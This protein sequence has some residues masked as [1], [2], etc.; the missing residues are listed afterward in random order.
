MKICK[1]CNTEKSLDQYQKHGEYYPLTCKSC[2][3][4]ARRLKYDPLNQ[5]VLTAKRK[6]K[7]M[8][9]K[10]NDPEAYRVY[11]DN[12]NEIS[13]TSN[14]KRRA[15]DPEFRNRSRAIGRRSYRNNIER[16]KA[17]AKK[18]KEHIAEVQAAYYKND[19]NKDKI[20][21]W[22]KNSTE[23]RKRRHKEDP[24]AYQ[25]YLKK[26]RESN[27]RYREKHPERNKIKKQRWIDANPERMK[28]IHRLQERKAINE[29]KDHYVAGLLRNK[30]WDKED[31]TPSLIELQRSSVKLHRLIKGNIAAK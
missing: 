28:E 22:A 25:A 14:R 10:E 1:T 8:L 20:D 17:Y 16:V 29:L 2:S 13:R 5:K 23:N 18:N 27:K 9:M 4:E 21:L 12:K 24:E 19:A 11:R 6:A 15:E 31:I 26:Q 7:V 30:G 3:A